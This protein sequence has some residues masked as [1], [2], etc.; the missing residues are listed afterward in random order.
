MKL[1]KLTDKNGNTKNNMHW[2]V[3]ITNTATGKDE[4]RLC[5]DTVLHAYT[6]LLLAELMN[7]AHSFFHDDKLVFEVEGKVV[8]SD[9]TKVGCKELTVIAVVITPEITKNQRIAFGIL[10]A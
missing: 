2:E 3:G 10:C 8:V 9:G 5:T 7:P 4:Y 1:Y 6:S